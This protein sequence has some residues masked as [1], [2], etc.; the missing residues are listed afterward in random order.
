VANDV[1]GA[2]ESIPSP[3]DMGTSA[4]GQSLGGF[5]LGGQTAPLPDTLFALTGEANVANKPWP[6]PGALDNG[7]PITFIHHAAVIEAVAAAAWDGGE[8]GN[9]AQ[10][11][12]TEYK[13][14]IS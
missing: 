10:D 8:F 12:A 11:L 3:E 2:P 14:Y 5:S 9:N 7:E 13:Q 6:V 1:E 4:T